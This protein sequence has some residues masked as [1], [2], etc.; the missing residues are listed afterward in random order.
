MSKWTEVDGSWVL[1][2]G[3]LKVS[4]WPA[5]PAGKPWHDP[6][7][8]G[9]WQWAIRCGESCLLMFHS[10]LPSKEAAQKAALNAA[11]QLATDILNAL[12]EVEEKEKPN[13]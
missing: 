2:A 1:E 12:D 8:M 9:T 13:D 7:D 3:S 11:R 10:R 4:V 5:P 6:N